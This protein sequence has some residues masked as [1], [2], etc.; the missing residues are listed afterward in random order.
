LPGTRGKD[1]E[2][3]VEEL[4]EEAKAKLAKNDRNGKRE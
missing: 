1:L 2:K 4:V 3:K